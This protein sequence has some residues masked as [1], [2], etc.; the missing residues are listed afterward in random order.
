M[1]WSRVAGKPRGPIDAGFAPR[2]R[3]GGLARAEKTRRLAKGLLIPF[4]TPKASLGVCRLEGALR[5]SAKTNDGDS[6]DQSETGSPH[7]PVYGATP[8]DRRPRRQQ[9]IPM[10]PRSAAVG[11]L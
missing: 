7:Q 9:A 5:R 3:K 10:A 4:S 6:S 1:K 8:G 11:T 2:L